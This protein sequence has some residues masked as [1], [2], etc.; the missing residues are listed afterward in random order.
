MKY[1]N[2]RLTALIV[3]RQ[4]RLLIRILT[5]E[6][7]Q[8]MLIG[9]LV[10]CHGA[11]QL[12]QSLASEVIWYC[13]RA[14][15]RASSRGRERE[16]RAV[17]LRYMWYRTRLDFS[18]YL[19]TAETSK[20]ESFFQIRS[21]STGSEYEGET[22]ARVLCLYNTLMNRALGI[23]D[24][25]PPPQVQV[26]LIAEGIATIAHT[27]R[28]ANDLI[29]QALRDSFADD[30][31]ALDLRGQT[32]LIEHVMRWSNHTNLSTRSVLNHLEE[33]CSKTGNSPVYFLSERGHH[34]F[35]ASLSARSV[36]RRPL[37]P[38]LYF[39]TLSFVTLVGGLAMWIGGI[40]RLPFGLVLVMTPVW[41]ESA[42]SISQ[43]L[44][45]R[46]R[47][48]PMAYGTSD[49]DPAGSTVVCIPT[50][51]SNKRM[52]SAVI[53]VVERNIPEAVSVGASIVILADPLDSHSPNLTDHDFEMMSYLEA[54]AARINL[55]NERIGIK[56]LA[57][58]RVFSPS[59]GTFIAW[60]RK[61]GKILE[62]FRATR[63]IAT[64]FVNSHE[65]ARDFGQAKY[66]MCIDDDCYITSST[67]ATL[68]ATA[69]SAV[70]Q[71]VFDSNGSVIR[72]HAI[73]IPCDYIAPDAARQW[74]DATRVVGSPARHGQEAM[75][76]NFQQ[77]VFGYRPFAG[78]GLIDIDAYLRSASARLESERILSHDVIEGA[79][80]RPLHVN[81]ASILEGFP[82][83]Y[84]SLSIRTHRWM[85]GDWQ[86]LLLLSTRLFLRTSDRPP[87]P[88][89]TALF[90]LRLARRSLVRVCIL[91]TIIVALAA[92]RSSGLHVLT[93]LFITAF[94]PQ[95]VDVVTA[96]SL[97][98]KLRAMIFALVGY[99]QTV[100]KA[101]HQG[102][103]SLDAMALGIFRWLSGQKL[104]QWTT[105][106]AVEDG[107]RGFSR[108]DW[109]VRITSVTSMCMMAWLL[110][111]HRL[112]EPRAL[113]LSMWA[114]SA[115]LARDR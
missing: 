88:V 25:S 87:V 102:L 54:Q 81:R 62:F 101:A 94:L 35:L 98:E 56:V 4:L 11:R 71:P 42:S 92:S 105:S 38:G 79:F 95:L 96:T 113:I 31:M 5:S 28:A 76:Q 49:P 115:F 104:L 19:A 30:F 78:K 51:L 83:T 99:F 110:G 77:L 65:I 43:W 109:I 69:Q 90:A 93:W 21:P 97:R 22:L 29:S 9:R 100:L 84:R 17:I 72:G 82:S 73:F 37:G 85:R 44:L 61:R 86:N 16:S 10:H 74:S 106:A 111:R 8:I 112:T 6:E 70:N 20:G 24:S 63:G 108:F 12:S 75:Q 32:A 14:I 1:F 67:L 40:S 57:R 89:P 2:H 58:Q 46:R 114:A 45:L 47:R 36:S 103:L 55:A 13:S 3:R 18:R 39:T 48:P 64:T 15:E 33:L 68:L 26:R 53:K 7:A 80:L 27:E 50:L 23:A 52:L 66:V 107:Q 91:V 34:E 59:E 41:L 60:E